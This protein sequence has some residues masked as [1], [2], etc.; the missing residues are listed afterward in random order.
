M[1]GQK[2]AESCRSAG[3]PGM[4]SPDDRGHLAG[5]HG[6]GCHSAALGA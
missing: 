6:D 2:G 1:H 4:K 5:L 3:L